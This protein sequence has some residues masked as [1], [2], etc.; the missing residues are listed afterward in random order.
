M[1][2]ET[3]L[4]P[5]YLSGL[6][7]ETR[8]GIGLL[9]ALSALPLI[10]SAGQT[11]G[12]WIFQRYSSNKKICLALA[13]AARTLWLIPLGA[14]GYWGWRAL[15]GPNP[16]PQTQWFILTAVTATLISL[17]SM[18]S[19][20]AWMSW[21]QRLV[22][23]KFH[24]RFFGTRQRFN[25]IGILV[26]NLLGVLAVGWK[27]NGV[28]AG[29]GLL[30][31]AAV[32]AAT[33][34]TFLLW[35]TPET[36]RSEPQLSKPHAEIRR[37]RVSPKVFLK[38]LQ[39]KKFRKILIYGA[40]T[41]GAIMLAGPYF[42]Y[43]FTKELQIPMSSVAFWSAM[44][45][46]GCF[47]AATYWGKLIDRIA[48]PKFILRVTG[49]MFAISP[50]PY[51]LTSTRILSWVGPI[52]YFINGFAHSGYMLT[53]ITILYRFAPKT[54]LDSSGRIPDGGIDMSAVYF[55]VYTAAVGLAGAL[56]TFLGGMLAELLTPWGGFRALWIIAACVRAAVV[57][58]LLKNIPKWPSRSRRTQLRGISQTPAPAI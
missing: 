21:T 49:L 58:L 6:A 18:S 31:V 32:V 9:A 25:M 5:T 4:G 3:L 1:A 15:T 17:V 28:F 29:Y 24:G 44:T 19:V 26:A 55:S 51:I 14:A 45:N 30:A 57:L 40:A 46:L 35:K 42:P 16:F 34:S 54:P 38:P 11:L 27:P 36:T 50:L 2:Y 23:E 37:K 13:I 33:I 41:N 43:Y 22:P 53:L 8:L 10:G 12:V 39:D 7:G 47:F 56:C 20:M 52:E 48:D